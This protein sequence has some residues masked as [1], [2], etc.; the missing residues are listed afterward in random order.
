M[1]FKAALFVNI[2][3]ITGDGNFELKQAFI[4]G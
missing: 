1:H 4:F 2:E 3:A